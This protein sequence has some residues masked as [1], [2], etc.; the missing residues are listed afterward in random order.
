MNQQ[1][2]LFLSI[3]LIIFLISLDKKK[4]ISVSYGLWIPLLWI[5]ILGSR[6]LTMWFNPQL[7]IDSPEDYLEGSPIDRAFFILLIVIGCIILARRKINWQMLV[8]NNMGL[9]L[10]L[11]Y[12]GMS[13]VWS[14][15]PVVSLKRWIK[16]FGNIIIVLIVIT[17]YDPVEAIKVLYKRCTYILI[18]LSIVFIKYFST[19]GRIYNRWTGE[20]Q[21][22]GVTTSKNELGMICF[23]FGIFFFWNLIE[24]FNKSQIFTSKKEILIEIIF[25]AMIIYLLKLSNSATSMLC[26]ALGIF[27]LLALRIN[28]IKRNIN[29]IGLY[30]IIS[31]FIFLMLEVSFDIT[32]KIIYLAGRDITLTGRTE[33]WSEVIRMTT[34]PILGTGYESF[35]LGSRAQI[36]WDKYYWHPNQSHNGY[37][38]IYINLGLLGLFFL[39]GFIFTSYRNISKGLVFNANFGSLRI[40]YFFVVLIYNITEATFKGLN[41]I[42][43]SFLLVAIEYFNVNDNQVLYETSYQDE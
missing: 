25:F 31:I 22:T 32:Q 36:L 23:I 10:L 9:F 18:P 6:P 7:S 39:L 13:I 33:I 34:N 16:G 21:Y 30:I 20:P 2:V 15:Y 1:I 5:L 26:F 17:E 38:E 27:I 8:K 24:K 40:T 29:Y 4:N 12:G 14:D 37:I 41:I 28:F 3:L 43:F 11:L 19:L 42:L 35:W